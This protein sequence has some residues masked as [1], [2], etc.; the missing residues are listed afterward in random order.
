MSIPLSDLECRLEFLLWSPSLVH[1]DRVSEYIRKSDPP[2]LL[3]HV[4]TRQQGLD[5]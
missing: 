3:C 1:S 2:N 5:M 4:S